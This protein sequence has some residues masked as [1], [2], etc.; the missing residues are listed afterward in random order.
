MKKRLSDIKH[1]QNL[2]ISGISSPNLEAKFAE[3]GLVS[4]KEIR[5]LFSA[6]MDDPIAIEVDGYI[7]SMRLDEA[8]Y[9]EVETLK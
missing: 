9:V 1:A 5:W 7:L 8:Q 2:M 3:M 4:G 6:P